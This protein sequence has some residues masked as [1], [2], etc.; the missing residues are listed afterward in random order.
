MTERDDV[1]MAV[2]AAALARVSS[3]RDSRVQPHVEDIAQDVV[4][5]YLLAV[6]R[7][8]IDNPEAWANRVAGRR[9]VDR[10]R[11]DQPVDAPVTDDDTRRSVENFLLRGQMTSNMVIVREQAA[12]MMALLTTRERKFVWLVSE[13]YTHQEIAEIMTYANAESARSTLARKR[14]ELRAIAD[15]EGLDPDWEDHPRAY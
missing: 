10:L 2:R 14:R 9:A 3:M 5:A 7:E 6:K 1:V 12:R 13:G 11:I 8:P 4:E 15:D